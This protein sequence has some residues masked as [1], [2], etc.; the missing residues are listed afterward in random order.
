VT[1]LET[2][3]LLLRELEEGDL[4]GLRAILQDAETMYAYEHAFSERE[5]RQWLERQQQRYREEGFGLWAVLLKET[6]A[7]IGQCG[8]T[9]QDWGARRVPEIGYLFN[10]GY[11]H[12]G[13]ATEAARACKRYAFQTLG[14]AEVFSIIRENNA[15]SRAVA[16]RNGMR[17]RGRLVKHYYGLDMPHLVYSVRR[18]APEPDML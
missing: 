17:V 9:M 12:R 13:Y 4:P 1:G 5:V 18:G 16:E 3:R 2:Q 6:G 11:W 10:R 14:L 8:L 15:P 7:F